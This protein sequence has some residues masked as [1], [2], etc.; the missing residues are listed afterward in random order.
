MHSSARRQTEEDNDLDSDDSGFERGY[1]DT[2]GAARRIAALL[3]SSDAAMNSLD[4]KA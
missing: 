2:T 4:R 1:V 3:K